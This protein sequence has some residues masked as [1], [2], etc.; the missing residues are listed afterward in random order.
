MVGVT[1]PLCAP[2]QYCHQ[3][4]DGVHPSVPGRTISSTSGRRSAGWWP[5]GYERAGLGARWHQRTSAS[6][7]LADWELFLDERGHSGGVGERISADQRPGA[8]RT[9]IHPRQSPE[10]RAFSSRAASPRHRRRR[11]H[12]ADGRLDRRGDPASTSG[13][14]LRR[15]GASTSA[16]AD[17]RADRGV[18][19][20]TP[21]PPLPEPGARKGEQLRLSGVSRLRELRAS[22]RVG[23][24]AAE[25]SSEAERCGGNEDA[26]PRLA[27]GSGHRDRGRASRLHGAGGAVRRDVL[28][29]A[30][31]GGPG[32]L[33]LLSGSAATTWTGRSGSC[34]SMLQREAASSDFTVTRLARPGSA[35]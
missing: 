3:T 11:R 18:A 23:L 24:G 22:F 2:A 13:M 17:P 20:R 35:S 25:H 34:T 8:R 26:P 31:G 4:D 32:A 15:F 21:R 33:G 28:S 29:S 14:D 16:P 9:G 5:A 1:I 7:T 10:V 19:A 27:G 30:G 12:R 6:A